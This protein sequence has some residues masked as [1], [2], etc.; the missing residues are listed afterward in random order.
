MI[1]NHKDGDKTNNHYKN[2]E[3]VTYSQNSLHSYNE[4]KQKKPHSNGVSKAIV[5]NCKNKYTYFDSVSNAANKTGVS[6]T[7]ILRLLNTNKKDNSGNVYLPFEWSLFD[8]I[9]NK[10]EIF[11]Y[12]KG[13]PKGILLIRNNEICKIFNSI[14]EASKYLN[15]SEYI[16]KKNH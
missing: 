4:L 7:Q 1:V 11:T 8:K 6:K 12:K 3:W 5:I 10:I 9:S 2:I 14:K 16:V 15:K 13:M